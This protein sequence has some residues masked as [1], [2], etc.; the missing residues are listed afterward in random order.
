MMCFKSPGRRDSLYSNSSVDSMRIVESDADNSDTMSV[1]SN[2]TFLAH[3]R[4]SR[5][6]L[7]VN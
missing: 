3:S 2:A 5:S 1:D 4:S 6:T 7:Q